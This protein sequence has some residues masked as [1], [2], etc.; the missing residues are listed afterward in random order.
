MNWAKLLHK[1]TGREHHFKVALRYFQEPGNGNRY[2][3]RVATVWAPDRRLIAN[4]RAIKQA[5]APE[6]I[7]DLP[8]HLRCNGTVLVR[9]VYY[10]GWFKPIKRGE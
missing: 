10:L 8:R 3:E 1:L 4:D 5:I 6:M 9:E 2:T 7:A